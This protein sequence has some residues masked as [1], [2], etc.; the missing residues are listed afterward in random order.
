[1][2]IL[3][4]KTNVQ[5]KKNLKQVMP[6][7]NEMKGVIKWNIDFHDRDKILRIVGNDLSPRVVENTLKNAGYTCEELT[8]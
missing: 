7:L 8:D 6:H 4:F 5:Y 1:M 3:V 2:E